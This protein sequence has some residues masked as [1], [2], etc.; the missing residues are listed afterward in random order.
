MNEQLH[1]DITS[2]IQNT[3]SEI[4][5]IITF[6]I[7]VL[8][9]NN[10]HTFVI[11]FLLVFFVYD[12]HVEVIQFNTSCTGNIVSMKVSDSSRAMLN[13]THDTNRFYRCL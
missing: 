6:W 8:K 7:F 10:C 4:K 11:I 2:L 9:N 1:T 12:Q 3:I 13:R 5:H